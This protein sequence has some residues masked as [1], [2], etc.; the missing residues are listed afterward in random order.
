MKVENTIT[1]KEKKLLLS[2]HT[3]RGRRKEQLFLAEGPKLIEELLKVYT[4]RWIIT[5]EEFYKQHLQDIKVDKLSLLPSSFK[6]STISSLQTPRPIIAVF[7]KPQQSS[8]FPPIKSLS[9]LLDNVQ[10]PGNVGTIIRTCD[11]LGIRT[12]YATEGTADIFSP[13]VMQ[14]TMGGIARVQVVYINEIESFL[15]DTSSKNIPLYGSFLEGEDIFSPSIA[16][17]APSSPAL[18]VM[19][20]EGNGISERIANAITHR[21]TIPAQ[22]SDGKHTESL[23]VAV[24]TSMLLTRFFFC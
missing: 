12:I 20:N 5:N 3:A 11:W 15:K 4:C 7:D 17:T 10:D 6:F 14:A 8:S 22:A 9:L 24:A 2:L 19:G 1:N 21:L 13:K 16:L 23:N 18:L